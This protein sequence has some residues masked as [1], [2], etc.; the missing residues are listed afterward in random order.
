MDSFELNYFQAFLI[1]NWLELFG[2]H[3]G[4]LGPDASDTSVHSHSKM[5]IELMQIGQTGIFVISQWDKGKV[6][7]KQAPKAGA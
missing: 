1:Q 3:L 7:D 2:R 5:E 6:Q 4:W